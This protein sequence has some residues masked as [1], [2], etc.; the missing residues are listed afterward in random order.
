MRV[1]ILAVC[2]AIA[3]LACNDTDSPVDPATLNASA[4]I[5]NAADAAAHTY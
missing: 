4:A 1:Q 3:A 5:D 2:L